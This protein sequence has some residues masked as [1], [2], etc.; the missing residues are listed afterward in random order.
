MVAIKAIGALTGWSASLAV[1][2]EIKIVVSDRIKG[3][4]H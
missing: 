3:V 4:G 2:V 1:F